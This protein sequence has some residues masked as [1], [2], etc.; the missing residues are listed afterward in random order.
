MSKKSWLYLLGSIAIVC[1]GYYVWFIPGAILTYGDFRFSFNDSTKQL[2]VNS[3][4]IWSPSGLGDINLGLTWLPKLFLNGLLASINLPS[5]LN[6]QLTYLWFI[7]L[8]STVGFFLLGKKVTKS[9]FGGFV[10]STIF[11]FSVTVI[12]TRTMHLTLASAYA[13]APFVLLFFI[14]ALESK[15]RLYFILT[16]IFACLLGINEIRVL[17]LLAF[18]LALYFI[19]FELLQKD[20]KKFAFDLSWSICAGALLLLLNLPWVLGFLF[21]GRDPE[22]FSF[23]TR[24]LFGN[25]YATLSTA[26]TNWN[27]WWTG[28]EVTFFSPHNVP[29]I[30]WVIPLAALFGFLI[31]RR[32]KQL[33]FFALLSIF[34]ILLAKQVASPWPDLYPWLYNY[35]PGFNVFRESSK[36]YFIISLGYSILIAGLLV[37]LCSTSWQAGKTK[38]IIGR[39]LAIFILAL[40]LINAV[41]LMTGSI[42]SLFE[43]RQIPGDYIALNKFIGDQPDF[44]RTYWLPIDS[45]WSFYSN[46]HPKMAGVVDVDG[47]WSTVINYCNNS[48]KQSIE[49]NLISVCGQS[50]SAQFF[51]LS[52]VKYIIVPLQDISNQDDFFV[53]YGGQNN[54]QIRDFYLTGLDNIKWLEKVNLN[55]SSLAIYE[56]KN[57]R[58]H[59]YLTPERETVYKD[60]PFS[61]IGWR[62][63]S[64]TKYHISLSHISSSVFLNFSE[65]YH[66]DWKLRVG[67]F[68]WWS[69]L[70]GKSYFLSNSIH[71]KNDAGLN[72]FYVD[73]EAIC[74]S[75]SCVK[76]GDGSYDIE[77]TLYFKAQ[78]FVLVGLVISGLT[79]FCLVLL[80]IWCILK[81]RKIKLSTNNKL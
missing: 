22:S 4:Q 78:A 54:A 61:F 44:F 68:H 80:L 8:F 17:Y 9:D 3:W 51:A 71:F 2:L 10:T 31:N 20:W 11:N 18:V 41:P 5:S 6:T 65:A 53:D 46:L 50:F 14:L 47:R 57:I 38:F 21:I 81:D 27:V 55:G 67:N 16:A 34:G 74:A 19:Y 1:L 72:S 45:R 30:F 52:A 40:F 23:L 66:P 28:R 25:E 13:V 49:N 70:L 60:V 79:L 73:P 64:P 77:L 37:K 48:A 12:G 76:N 58:P 29:F 63:D 32:N 24:G 42:R 26:L 15:R 75:G 7:L 33:V 35:F 39:V 69:S 36:F 62:F 56:N 43:P 59:L